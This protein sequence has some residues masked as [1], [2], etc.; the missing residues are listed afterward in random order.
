MSKNG[1]IDIPLYDSKYDGF[2]FEKNGIYLESHDAFQLP[3]LDKGDFKA[4]LMGGGKRI[5]TMPKEKTIRLELK[6]A[7]DRVSASRPDFGLYQV[8]QLFYKTE[9]KPLVIFERPDR[10][11]NCLLKSSIEV[12][13][14]PGF[15]SLT[16]ALLANDPLFYSLDEFERTFLAGTD[17]YLVMEGNAPHFPEIVIKGVA[18]NPTLTVANDYGVFSIRYSG[19]L[20]ASD[21]WEIHT[22]DY[23]SNYNTGPSDGR[24]TKDRLLIAP[25]TNVFHLSQGTMT[26]KYRWSWY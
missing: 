7:N 11:I 17:N 14:H 25:G 18:V 1:G 21:K 2:L 9:P 5:Y 6:I 24:V 8:M 3:P 4:D 20:G 12:S 13:D 26:M 15:T 19:S 10:Y 23:R 22:R 16:V